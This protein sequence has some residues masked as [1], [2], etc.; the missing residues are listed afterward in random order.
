MPRPY[1]PR[2]YQHSPRPR[3]RKAPLAPLAPLVPAALAL[4]AV[5]LAWH[6]IASAIA[7]IGAALA[8]PL[9]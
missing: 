3:P 2:P 1:R 9:P 5:V 6:G 7:H 4:L 8:L